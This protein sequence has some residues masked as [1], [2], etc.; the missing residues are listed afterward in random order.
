MKTFSAALEVSLI[1]TTLNFSLSF[2]TEY[3][4][5]SIEAAGPDPFWKYKQHYV[6]NPLAKT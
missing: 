1:F 6:I 3:V 5:P 2:L 4:G